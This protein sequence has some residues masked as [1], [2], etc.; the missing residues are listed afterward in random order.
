[1][2]DEES[3]EGDASRTHP[4]RKRATKKT[5]TRARG[6]FDFIERIRRRAS[7]RSVNRETLSSTDKSSSTNKSSSL[8][9]APS[10]ASSIIPQHSSVIVGIGDDAAVIRSP[11]SSVDTIITTDLLVEDIDF[12]LSTTSPRLLGH[13]ALA[14]SLSD[15][16]AMGARPRHSLLSIGANA[17]IWASRFLEDFY[18]GYFELAYAHGVALVGGDVSRTGARSGARRGD[19][20][21][22]V[23]DSIVIGEARRARAVLRSGARPG[24]QIF[25]TGALGGAAAGLR[26]LQK[27]ERLKKGSETKFKDAAARLKNDS[28]RL[29]NSARDFN[30][31][32]ARQRLILRQLRPAPRV[33]LGIF[34]GDRL[35]ASSMI[36]LSD[37]LSSD[38][39]HI[40]RESG[41]GATIE[42]ASI[43]I[44][45]LIERALNVS[46][47]Q[48]LETAL[49]GGEDFELLFTLGPRR[50]ARAPEEIGGVKVTRIGEITDA[51]NRIFLKSERKTR[52][53]TA[54]GFRH[55]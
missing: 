36:D 50:A 52:E 48:A 23:I 32:E 17:R 4:V 47:R 49:N 10:S 54:K 28:A 19:V 38:L 39:S 53:L 30:L 37:G 46:E 3:D 12:R 34:L 44:D 26:L 16:A 2:K 15:V 25:V 13:K 7:K 11:R 18:E 43:P 33:A 24:D 40:C 27:G 29:K 42:A 5:M 45:P 41:V 35:R 31:S 51:A 21:P 20:G 1:M 22:L 55:F 6:E 8:S 9:S 14:V